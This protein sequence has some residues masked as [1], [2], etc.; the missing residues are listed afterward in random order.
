MYKTKSRHTE[1]ALKVI[2][3][4]VK[5]KNLS[6]IRTAEIPDE[7]REQLACFV[8]IHLKNGKLR[9]C[10]GTIQPRT[11]NLYQEIITNAISAATNDSRFNEVS[12]EELEDLEV[13]VDVLSKPWLIENERELDPKKLGVIVTDGQFSRGVLLPNIEG[14]D[15]AE[16][17]LN[18]AKRKASLSHIDNNSL[19]IYAF[20][21][22]RYY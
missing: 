3:L 12:P 17:Q 6:T 5:N 21:S 1:L 13:S 14:V 20:T 18:I 4:T 16:Q 11:D 10:I 15:S 19:Q 22:T 8:S 2:E 7:L 9:G